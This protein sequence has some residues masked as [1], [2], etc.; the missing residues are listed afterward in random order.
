MIPPATAFAAAPYPQKREKEEGITIM[1]R[2]QLAINAIRV[3]SAQAIEKAKSGHP[4]MPLGAAPMGYALWNRQMKH[5]PANP[6]WIDRDRFVLSAGHGSMLLYSILHLAGYDVTMEDIKNFRQLGSRTPGHPEFGVTAGVDCSTGPLGQGIANAVG[7]AMA[8]KHLAAT[9]NRPGYEIVDHNTYVIMG[10]GCMMEGITQEAI[11]IAGNLKL[12]KLI[13][14][15][16]DNNISI[17]GDT[18]CTF[19]ED[20]VARF[21]ACG[22]NVIDLAD[23]MDFKAISK[24]IAIAKKSDKPTLIVCHTVIGYGSPAARRTA[25]S[26]ASLEPPWSSRHSPRPAVRRGMPQSL[27]WESRSR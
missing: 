13:A 18:D 19:T 12:N 14:L 4:G 10:D 7:M 26:A 6:Q 22:W 3:L 1:N 15:Y 11:S 2:D 23:G 17:E 20:V 24:A 9:F 27:P 8:E 5:N 16:D 25:P 21:R